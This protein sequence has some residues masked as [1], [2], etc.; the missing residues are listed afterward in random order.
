VR[1]LPGVALAETGSAHPSLIEDDG[2]PGLRRAV[3]SLNSGQL[4][5]YG[6]AGGSSPAMTTLWA[7]PVADGADKAHS[8]R[9]INAAR[10]V[11]AFGVRWE[12]GNDGNNTVERWTR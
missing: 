10:H 11:R 1:S 4:D 5:S 9:Y 2:L 7:I 8:D 6:R 3:A 12:A